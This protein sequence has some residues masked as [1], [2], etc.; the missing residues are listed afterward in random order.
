MPATEAQMIIWIVRL[1]Q[2]SG[3]SFRQDLGQVI[4]YVFAPNDS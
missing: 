3:E 4:E 2:V 1:L